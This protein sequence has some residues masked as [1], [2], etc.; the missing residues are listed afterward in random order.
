VCVRC[1]REE[2]GADGDAGCSWLDHPLDDNPLVID[3]AC[4][5][6]F[7]RTYAG[8]NCVGDAALDPPLDTACECTG[9][10]CTK[11]CHE[12][13]DPSEDTWTCYW[14]DPTIRV[15]PAV[16]PPLP[17]APPGGYSPLALSPPSVSPE[18]PA[19]GDQKL[20]YTRACTAC[21]ID[22][23]AG[24]HV[25]LSSLPAAYTREELTL[26]ERGCDGVDDSWSSVIDCATEELFLVQATPE[27]AAGDCPV[28]AP[29][30]LPPPGA[31][32]FDDPHVRTLSGNQF[33]L[34]GVGIFDYASIPGV[35]TTQVYMCPFAPCTAEMMETGE[36]LTFITA[37][38]VRLENHG[39][40]A[41][42][43]T[44]IL[45][46]SSLR[47]DSVD[48]MG[49]A[50]VTLASHSVIEASG[51]GRASERTERVDH[52]TLADCHVLPTVGQLVPKANRSQHKLAAQ[53]R[54]GGVW[55]DCTRNEWTLTTPEMVMNIGVI[56]P[57]EEGYLREAAGDRTFN[58]DVQAIRN[59]DAL[60]GV[61]NGDKNGLFVLD[62]ELNPEPSAIT[63]TLVP[64][65][66]H[67]NVQEV[68][69]ANVAPEDSLFPS[70]AMAKMDAACGAQQSLRAFRVE[71]GATVT[72]AQR[73][74]WKSW[75]SW[76]SR[77][78]LE[79]RRGK[80]SAKKKLP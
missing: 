30:S 65:G 8:T 14:E 75:K 80:K 73:R 68:T 64:L 42:A 5:Y 3:D 37:V 48:R 57:F 38:A 25:D 67:G 16:P 61:I 62:P 79:T 35:L 47:V 46:N 71:E 55:Q 9:G 33:F 17:P 66:P 29:P 51:V 31:Q 49:E 60:K 7:S 23:C 22:W 44:L 58:L 13:Y 53:R 11:C 69:A 70:A 15:P 20:F 76:K 24:D 39:A 77:S 18:V 2:L 10:E 27:Q 36:C 21:G 26:Q 1:C 72:D 19:A 32:I 74:G 54:G 6:G 43:H 34:H 50:N 56:G 12:A 45:R 63:P 28:Q 4:S 52:Q 59:Q 78:P 41:P 40:G